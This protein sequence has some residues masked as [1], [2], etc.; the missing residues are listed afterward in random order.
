MVVILLII[1]KKVTKKIIILNYF[2]Q[3]IKE[4]E[5]D[6]LEIVNLLEG[7]NVYFITNIDRL[8]KKKKKNIY[9]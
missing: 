3:D 8:Q 5:K 2:L 1:K 9:K 7:K 4:L 6:I